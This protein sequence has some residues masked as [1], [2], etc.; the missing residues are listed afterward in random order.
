MTK[1]TLRTLVTLA[2]V[3]ALAVQTWL[4]YS[5]AP[6]QPPADFSGSDLVA[7]LVLFGVPTALAW[8]LWPKWWIIAVA[9]LYAPASELL[10]LF[11]PH[12]SSESA[13]MVADLLGVALG[14]V[15]AHLVRRV[16]VSGTTG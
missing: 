9:V 8:W 5:P 4:L 1:P 7:H 15:L 16:T 6:P 2:L 13:D 14:L 12:R 10:Q 3:L 11:V